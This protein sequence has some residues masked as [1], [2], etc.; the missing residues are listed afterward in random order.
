[1]IGFELFDL[2]QNTL[3]LLSAGHRLSP[4]EAPDSQALAQR[5]GQ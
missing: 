4:D 5:A 2:S 3:N 1:L